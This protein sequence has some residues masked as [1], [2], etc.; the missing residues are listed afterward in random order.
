MRPYEAY[1]LHKSASEQGQ[2]WRQ[3]A[4]EH[5]SDAHAYWDK[6]KPAMLRSTANNLMFGLLT[7][8]RGAG[9]V[10]LVGS[11]SGGV[12]DGMLFKPITDGAIH[13]VGTGLR[14]FYGLSEK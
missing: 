6:N 1:W 11:S 13:L 14:K 8:P 12:I 10:S 3:V 4:R 7:S 5:L 9:P 2:D